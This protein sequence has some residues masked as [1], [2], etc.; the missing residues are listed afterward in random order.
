[1]IARFFSIFFISIY[2]L[3]C[4]TREALFDL[5]TQMQFQMNLGLSTLETHNYVN[6]VIIP[7]DLTLNNIGIME[8]D[9]TEVVAQ[10][11]FLSPRF[12]DEVNLDFIN[13][14]QISIVDQ[15]TSRTREIFYLDFVNFGAK[16]QIEL[17]PSL[18]DIKNLLVNDK[19]II[20]ASIRLR[21][22]PPVTFDMLLDMN[23]A[24]FAEE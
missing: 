21:Q 9:I 10:T 19:A 4:G 20:N 2:F 14:V 23:F 12:N 8:S 11:A 15:E 22:F 3:S 16:Q 7:L 13:S 24:A 6:E 17:I 18:T 1:M 5:S